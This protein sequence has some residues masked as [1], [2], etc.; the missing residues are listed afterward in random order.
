MTE[1]EL[2][3]AAKIFLQKNY[4]MTLDIPVKRNN[5]LR[6]THGRFVIKNN[7]A[8]SIELAGYLLEYDTNESVMGVLKHECIHYAQFKKGAA[9]LDGDP[10]FEYELHKHA[11]PRTRT[12]TI[13]KYIQFS[14][15][16]CGKTTETKRKR[17]M[18]YPN[19]YRTTCCGSTLTIL[20]ERIFDGSE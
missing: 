9:H 7:T 14:C 8:Y 16:A 5:R 11:A 2:N 17:V 13:G 10:T 15:D 18:K 20:G 3:E 4:Q 6:S 12:L 1:A 19:N